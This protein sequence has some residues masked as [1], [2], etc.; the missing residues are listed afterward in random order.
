VLGD[1]VP[2]IQGIGGDWHVVFE[3]SQDCGE[4]EGGVFGGSI[5]GEVA[6]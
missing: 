5:P 4:D 2:G 6:M 1:L 3:S